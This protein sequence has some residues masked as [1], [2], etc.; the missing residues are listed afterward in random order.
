MWA[1]SSVLNEGIFQALLIQGVK[2]LFL[3]LFEVNVF[4]LEL[5][6]QVLLCIL[7]YNG[8]IFILHPVH[9]KIDA[10]CRLPGLRPATSICSFPK[11]YSHKI[12]LLL[13][14]SLFFSRGP[15]SVPDPKGPDRS[16]IFFPK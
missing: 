13:L 7:N 15:G 8:I 6:L 14:R 2:N 16:N 4:F 3:K 1:L 5:T 12:H 11:H 9:V 10:I